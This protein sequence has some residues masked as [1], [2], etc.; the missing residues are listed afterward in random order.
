MSADNAMLNPDETWELLCDGPLYAEIFDAK[1]P[2]RVWIVE[3]EYKHFS[4]GALALETRPFEGC[5]GLVWALVEAS[6]VSRSRGGISV[7]FWHNGATGWFPYGN[8]RLSQSAAASRRAS[9]VS[10]V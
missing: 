10:S 2:V 9:T 8:A 7:D 6:C 3:Y 4:D 1:V 5:P